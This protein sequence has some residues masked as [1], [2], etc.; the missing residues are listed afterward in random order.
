MGVTI[1]YSWKSLLS[2][3]ESIV[4]KYQNYFSP[5]TIHLLGNFTQSHGFRSPLHANNH[6]YPRLIY[7]HIHLPIKIFTWMS[8]QYPKQYIFKNK[9]LISNHPYPQLHPANLQLPVSFLSCPKQSPVH[10]LCPAHKGLLNVL[11]T[12]QR[13]PSPQGLC[14]HWCLH[15]GCPLP[16]NPHDSPAS[17]SLCSNVTFFKVRLSKI[18]SYTALFF[19]RD[20]A[21][22]NIYL[23]SFSPNET[24]SSMM[25]NILFCLVPGI[26]LA[27]KYL[28][29]EW[30][31]HG[32]ALFT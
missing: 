25:L 18:S 20:P 28:L 12:N 11:Q 27:L 17:L 19:F 26:Q 7:I 30:V 2:M 22:S 8:T 3:M 29:N 15:L 23:L 14:G 1:K 6:L 32:K 4:P 13:A 31:N 21:S 16:W 24:V 9:L 10:S 5:I